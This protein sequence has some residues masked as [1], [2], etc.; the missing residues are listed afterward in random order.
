MV[1]HQLL[2]PNRGRKR[3]PNLRVSDRIIAGCAPFSCLFVAGGRWATEIDIATVGATDVTVRLD[4]FKPDGTPL[5][6]AMNGQT[7]SSFQNLTVKAGGVL[8]LAPATGI[9]IF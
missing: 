8:T 9:P 2:I 6:S 5:V 1:R 3:T 7:D 4:L